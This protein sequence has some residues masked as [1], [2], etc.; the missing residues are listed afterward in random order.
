MLHD[1]QLPL[2]LD[3]LQNDSDP[4]NSV[5]ELTIVSV[6]TPTFGTVDIVNNQIV[7]TPSGTE[8]GTVTFTYTIQDP[9]GLTSVATVTLQYEF[10]ELKVSEGFSPNNDGNNETWYIRAI[11]VY[12]DNAVQVYD[13]WGIMVYEARHYDNSGVVWDGRANTGVQS[14]KLVDKGTYFYKLSLGNNL[15]VLSG[16]VVLL[17]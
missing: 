7:Y 16:Y 1:S 12:P 8:S 14:G 5:S 11:E 17:K 2:T 15:K 13:R 9:K 3:V 4:D 10:Q 6:G